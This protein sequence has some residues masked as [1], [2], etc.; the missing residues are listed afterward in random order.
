VFAALP[1]FDDLWTR[2]Q[3]LAECAG[4]SPGRVDAVLLAA[5]HRVAHHPR[6]AD[7]LWSID[8]HLL[9][10]CLEAADWDELCTRAREC[11]VAAVVGAELG[12]ARER[13]GTAVSDRHVEFLRGT[14]AEPSAAYLAATGT[15]STEWLN[16]RHQGSLGGRLS[17]VIEHVFPSPTYMHDR[18]GT[19]GRVPLAWLYL[20]RAVMGGFRWMREHHALRRGA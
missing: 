4:V 1:T 16:F 6:S 7:V 20:R 12:A 19:V 5:V 8:M 11:R 10:T 3:P 17:L 14:P 9:A 18:Y 13:W 2:R 15:W